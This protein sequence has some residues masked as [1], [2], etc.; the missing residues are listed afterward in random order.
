MIKTRFYQGQGLGNQL[1]M[2][3]AV[4]GFALQR[5]CAHKIECAWR[6]KGAGFLEIDNGK[7]SCYFPGRNPRKNYFG[8]TTYRFIEKKSF[9]P[10]VPLDFTSFQNL[11]M[12]HRI[13]IEG[14]FESEGYFNAY[15]DIIRNELQAKNPIEVPEN[16]CLI[17]V[18]GKDFIGNSEVV[19]KRDYY[20]NAISQILKK[21]P[22]ASFAIVTDDVAYA[23]R[24]VPGITILSRNAKNCAIDSAKI[25]HDF[26]LLQNAKML[27][28]S[29]SSFGWWA[30]WT[31]LNHPLVVAPR[32]WAAHNLDL[33]IWSP[34]SI[35][36]SNWYWLSKEGDLRE[37][38]LEEKLV[39]EGLVK[40][41]RD[42]ENLVTLST[43]IPGRTKMRFRSKVYRFLSRLNLI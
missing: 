28:I 40:S 11:P 24:V 31:N 36:T 41:S 14:N 25:A 20:E 16:L 42:I 7:W 34:N 32:F 13:R 35:L 22:C 10:N 9:I 5:Q 1:W 29:N 2:Y 26:T 19:L 8:L 15:R 6:F 37:S 43:W 38:K 21:N 27:I 30:A 17:N 3:A 23:K 12:K 18:R 33:E 4:R 39:K